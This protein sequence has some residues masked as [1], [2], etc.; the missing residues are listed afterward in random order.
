MKRK[1]EWQRYHFTFAW[2]ECW[3]F[4]NY[5][6]FLTLHSTILSCSNQEV[7]IWHGV[8]PWGEKSHYNCD[9]WNSDNPLHVGLASH[10]EGGLIAKQK[11]MSCNNKFFVLCIEMWSYPDQSTYCTMLQKVSKCEV[12]AWLCC[13]IISLDFM[14]NSVLA[15]SIGP[16]MSFLAILE[17]LNFEFW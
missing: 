4:L 10:L 14:W 2:P 15:N 3:H 6:I 7:P 8:N 16:K 5:W 9:D 13:L 1:V 17:T 12:K 11:K